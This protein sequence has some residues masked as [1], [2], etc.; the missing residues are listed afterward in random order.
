MCR[1]VTRKGQG[2]PSIGT[3]WGGGDTHTRPPSIDPRGWAVLCAVTFQA[4]C[5]TPLPRAER[6]RRP[7]EKSQRYFGGNNP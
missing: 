6:T 1:T 7:T 3:T 2:R 5:E 4:H